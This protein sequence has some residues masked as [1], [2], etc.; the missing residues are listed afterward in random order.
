MVFFVTFVNLKESLLNIS[1]KPIEFDIDL[2]LQIPKTRRLRKCKIPQI[3]HF[4]KI[5]VH[6]N[7]HGKV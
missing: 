4:R 3:W 1:Y 6:S 7:D 5:P 2:R